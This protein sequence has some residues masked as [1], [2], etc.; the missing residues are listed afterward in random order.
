MRK[1]NSFLEIGFW[2]WLVFASAALLILL[3][4]LLA[5]WG[6]PMYE[7]SALLVVV[8]LYGI[9]RLLQA[10]ADAADPQA[11]RA[12]MEVM[13]STGVQ[14]T[15]RLLLVLL[16]IAVVLYGLLEGFSSS[17]I[18]VSVLT[19]LFL[20]LGLQRTVVPPPPYPQPPLPLPS[21]PSPSVAPSVGPQAGSTVKRYV[22][23]YPSSRGAPERVFT[24]ILTILQKNVDVYRSRSRILDSSKWTHYPLSVS[25][26]VIAC[27]GDLRQK[28]RDN[29]FASFDE[30]C[31][32]VCFVQHFPYSYDEQSTGQ[33]EYPRYPLET[34]YDET[35]DCEC[36]SILGASLLKLLGYE[37]ALLDYPGHIALGVAGAD[38]F[39]GAFFVD[40]ATG[41]RYYYVEMTSEG[42]QVGEV[43]IDL[44]NV[45]PRVLPVQGDFDLLQ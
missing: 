30:I 5:P 35:G 43:P 39:E 29:Y 24:Q 12:S 1:K 22:W 36:L 21:E 32:T 37:V 31:N 18:V 23:N 2:R 40:A 7:L 38:L 3:S 6:F 15:V 44:R 13:D 11:W 26:E 20:L 34:L 45:S 33:A 9:M 16:P 41:Q 25:A 4:P 8:A 14:R 42:W 19:W 17:L 28:H 10:V 27:A